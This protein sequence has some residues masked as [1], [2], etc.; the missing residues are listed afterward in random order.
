MVRKNLHAP[1]PEQWKTLCRKLHGHYEY[2]GITGNPVAVSRFL[3]FATRIWKRSLDRRSQRGYL[4]WAKFKR[5]LRRFPLPSARC[6][7]S[8]IPKSSE[9]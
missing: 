1:L 5:L 8:T 6:P 7:R 3:W 2:Y 9:A 4:P